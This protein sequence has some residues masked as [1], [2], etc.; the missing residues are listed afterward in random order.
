ML[1]Y[2]LR[3]LAFF[4][5]T[6]LVI[7]VIVFALSKMTPGDPVEN[8]LQI[9]PESN[10]NKG[11]SD[12]I[13][14][15]KA[16]ELGLDKPIFYMSFSA[17]AFPKSLYSIP[18]KDQ[19]I[20]AENLIKQH[21]NW[22]KILEFQQS[23]K[24]FLL[25]LNDNDS[26]NFKPNAQQLLI[27]DDDEKIVFIL[28]E[29]NQTAVEKGL[30]LREIKDIFNTYNAIKNQP[31]RYKLF[32]PTAHWYGFDNQYHHWLMGFL[33]GNFGAANDG[34]TIINK[35]RR[36][37][38]ITLIMSLLAI[39]LSYFIA[40]PIGIFTAANKN[41]ISG[42]WLMR[43]LFAAYSLPTFW[44][45]LMALRFLTTPQYGMKI[46]PSAG[47]SDLYTEVSFLDFFAANIGRLILPILCMIIHPTA[48]IARQLQGAMLEN[49]QLDYIRTAR[50]KG[51]AWQ[52]ILTHHAFKNASFPLITLLGHLLPVLITGSFIVEY[53][54]NIKGMGRVAYEAIGEQDWNVVYAVLML[55]AVMVLVGNLVSDLLYKWAN[56]RVELN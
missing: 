47:L 40:I 32:M 55:S 51:L 2:T 33:L 16:H 30:F 38:S 37:L 14:E 8:Q 10:S 53:I 13:Y 52:R 46:F 36:P 29:M 48:I 7:S 23:I 9:D 6:M 54:F 25:K 26:L 28:N 21:G 43:S 35:I 24:A 34:Q 42:K 39:I 3:R 15:Q 4:I 11:F 41:K 27:Q 56:P 19:R 12:K 49:L 17:Q 31:T 5:P 44:V 18:R 50:A 45:A 20:A 1:K 22:D